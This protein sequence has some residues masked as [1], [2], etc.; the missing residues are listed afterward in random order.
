M[1]SRVFLSTSR[2]KSTTGR[3]LVGLPNQAYL[4]A[5]KR[6]TKLVEVGGQKTRQGEGVSE[7]WTF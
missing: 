5:I 3:L 6:K 2:V 4:S 1:T 7:Y